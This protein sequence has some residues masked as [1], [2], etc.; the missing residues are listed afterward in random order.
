MI[1]PFQNSHGWITTSMYRSRCGGPSICTHCRLEY[2][3]VTGDLH[4]ETTAIEILLWDD[5]STSMLAALSNY[6]GPIVLKPRDVLEVVKAKYNVGAKVIG[7]N[8]KIV[9]EEILD[10]DPEYI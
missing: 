5:R 1:K 9:Y 3:H 10:L 7:K 4:P 2:Y 6:I 8:I